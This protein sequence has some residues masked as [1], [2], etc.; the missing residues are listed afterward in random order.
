MAL[1]MMH[2][3]GIC[4]EYM[5]YVYHDGDAVAAVVA[6]IVEKVEIC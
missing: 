2:K 3:C 6:A 1:C 4:D 5:R